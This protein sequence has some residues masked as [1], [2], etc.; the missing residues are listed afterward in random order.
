MKKVLGLLLIVGALAGCGGG[1]GKSTITLYNGQH[2]QLIQDLVNAFEKRTGIHVRVRTNDGIVLAAQLLQEGSHSPADVY[3]AENS[4]ELEALSEHN[5]FSRLP[6]SIT[7]QI[8]S[9]YNSPSGTWVGQALRASSLAYNPSA[10]AAAQLPKH[11][12]DLAKPEW[13]GKI[14]LAPTDSDFPPL[15]G[16]VIATYGKAAATD[17][18]NGLKANAVVY[19]DEEAV[20]SAVD[21]GDQAVGVTNSYYWYRL[22]LEQG[23]ANTKSKV[24]F[25]PNHDVGTVLN[26]AGAGVVASSHNKTNAESFVRFLVSP[27]GQRILSRGDDFEYPARPGVAANPALP[28]L[29]KVAPHDVSVAR[30]GDDQESASLIQQAGFG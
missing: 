27:E 9:K 26:I 19:A 5:M 14:A 3:I 11:V 13:Q 29:S 25:F 1:E 17:W 4:P 6:T 2:P 20:V 21:R 22:Q 23:A 15:L 24:Y 12:L 18:L 8:P 30:L 10:I 16:A 7:S 28:P